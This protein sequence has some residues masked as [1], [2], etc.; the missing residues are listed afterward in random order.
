MGLPTTRP[1]NT[2]AVRILG[3]CEIMRSPLKPILDCRAIQ[4]MG[5]VTMETGRY[6]AVTAVNA[7]SRRKQGWMQTYPLVR[8]LPVAH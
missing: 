7:P 5:I 3:L 4:N 1:T 6:E 2:N 8:Q